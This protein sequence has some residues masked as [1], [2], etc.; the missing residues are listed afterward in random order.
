MDR[1]GTSKASRRN[2]RRSAKGKVPRG[3]GHE[4]V[5]GRERPCSL[6]TPKGVAPPVVP[7]VAE[8]R[9]K[10]RPQTNAG[11]GRTRRQGQKTGQRAL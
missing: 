10:K 4:A 2:C 8:L 3:L 11:E 7:C 6:C 5:Q 9:Q 1:P